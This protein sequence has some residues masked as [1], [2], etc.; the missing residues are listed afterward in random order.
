[1]DGNGQVYFIHD[2]EMADGSSPNNR[3]S[4]EYP[5]IEWGE[6][7]WSISNRNGDVGVDHFNLHKVIKSD[8]PISYYSEK[9][10]N[11]EEVGKN[12]FEFNLSLEEI[13]DNKLALSSWTGNIDEKNKI[14]S[15]PL[16]IIETLKRSRL[17]GDFICR[18][19]SKQR[20]EK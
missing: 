16:E 1:M 20:I 4:E 17:C 14:A 9:N 19:N 5:D 13:E 8:A 11:E 15:L 3:P 18:W 7:T 10:D 6:Y 2:E 12:P